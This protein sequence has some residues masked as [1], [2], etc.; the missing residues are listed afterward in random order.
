MLDELYTGQMNQMT[1]GGQP[2]MN[3]GAVF[4]HSNTMQPNMSN[5]SYVGNN[6]MGVPYDPNMGMTGVCFLPT[7]ISSI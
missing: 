7:W 3:G 6:Q 1:T 2:V 5:P 4:G